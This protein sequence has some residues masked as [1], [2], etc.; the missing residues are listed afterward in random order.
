MATKTTQERLEKLV[1][2]RDLIIEKA[3]LKGAN[4]PLN[5]DFPAIIAGIES[6]ILGLDQVSVET[7]LDSILGEVVTGDYTVKGQAIEDAKE[8]IRQAIIAK[9]VAV[10]VETPLSQYPAKIT[11]I[12]GGSNQWQIPSDWEDLSIVGD[13]EIILIVSGG[14]HLSFTITLNDTSKTY[15]VSWGDGSNNNYTGNGSTKPTHVYTPGTGFMTSD[16]TEIWYIHITSTYNITRFNVARAA[17]TSYV[18]SPIIAAAFG[19]QY[20]TSLSS[21]FIVVKACCSYNLKY[22]Y[23]KSLANCTSAN[24]AFEKC[25]ALERVDFPSSFGSVSNLTNM[26]LD[27]SAL[28]S[29]K[30][31]DSWGD[32]TNASNMFRSC[33]ALL[34]VVL[35]TTWGR[36]Q[37]VVNMF[38]YCYSLKTVLLPVNW[39]DIYNANAMFDHCYNID[40]IKLP[41]SWGNVSF[42]NYFFAFCS[43]LKNL[44]MFSSFGNVSDASYMFVNCTSLQH[45]TLPS[46]WGGYLTKAT[47][48]FSGCTALKSVTLPTQFSIASSFD[49]SYIFDSCH[50]LRTIN[51]FGGIGWEN[52]ELDLSEIIVQANLITGVLTFSCKIKKLSIKAES[53]ADRLGITG[54]RLTNPNSTF[55]GYT[56]HINVSYCNMNAES[57][58]L[59]FGDLPVLSGKTIIVT[60]NPGAATCDPTIA[61]AKGWTVTT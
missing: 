10:P 32:V 14:E 23:I 30:L 13:N 53:A 19:G 58:N 24:N 22:V 57:L 9:D 1:L 20:L 6:I 31:P 29:V 39:G 45:I 52:G 5:S 11:E 56:Q 16:G 2:H 55:S 44:T 51:N 18:N 48:M 54:I 38:Y 42:A 60:G 43:S 35:P 59:L 8:A 61:T 7:L 27:C 40:N 25:K 21:A 46:T 15:N 41:D 37:Q 26:F 4:I 47:A 50:A 49:L 17:T 3:N 33:Y 34:E 12:S 36:V 28:K